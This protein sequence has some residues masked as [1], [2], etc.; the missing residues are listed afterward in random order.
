M[1]NAGE[2]L[3]MGLFPQ[4]FTDRGGG[5]FVTA[6]LGVGAGDVGGDNDG[7]VFVWREPHDN[8]PHGV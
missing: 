5:G 4:P 3:P 7:E 1:L 6:L 8:V 2:E